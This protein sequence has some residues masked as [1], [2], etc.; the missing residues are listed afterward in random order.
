MQKTNREVAGHLVAVRPDSLDGQAF[1]VV[2][3]KLRR[4]PSAQAQQRINAA[5]RSRESAA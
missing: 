1:G 4:S 2:R 3:D 5:P